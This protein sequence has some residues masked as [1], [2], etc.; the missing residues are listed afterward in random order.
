[1]L[2]ERHLHVSLV[3]SGFC[4]KYLDEIHFEGISQITE[5]IYQIKQIEYTTERK[6]QGR[7][8]NV[9]TASLIPHSN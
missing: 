1:M 6:Y 2:F 4:G 9:E 7:Q 8:L 5:R 3:S